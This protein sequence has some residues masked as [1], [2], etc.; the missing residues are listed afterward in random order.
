MKPRRLGRSGL[1]VSPVCLGTMMFGGQTDFAEAEK[2]ADL[3]EELKFEKQFDVALV[4]DNIETAF[5]EAEA[6][7]NK[8]ISD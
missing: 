6:L 1:M 7:V 2:I 8:F 3:A 4:N 5:K